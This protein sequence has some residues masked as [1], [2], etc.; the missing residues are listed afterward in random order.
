MKSV[1][2][3]SLFAWVVLELL[4]AGGSR[5]H[6]GLLSVV[7]TA[8]GNATDSN[9]DGTYDVLGIPIGNSQ[10]GL[11]AR[12]DLLGG[13]N[14][15]QRALIEFSLAGLA[16]TDTVTSATFRF[17]F[18]SR[19]WEIANPQVPVQMVGYA[20][21]GAVTMADATIAGPVVVPVQ[22]YFTAPFG[23]TSVAVDPTFVQGLLGN[24][25]FLGVRIEIVPASNFSSFGINS[26]EANLAFFSPPHPTLDIEFT[27]VQSVPEPSSL[28]MTATFLGTLA[29]FARRRAVKPPSRHPAR[30]K[31]YVETRTAGNRELTSSP[32]PSDAN[33]TH[34]SSAAFR[35]TGQRKPEF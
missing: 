8:N 1:L 14:L 35:S 23:E 28:A 30:S 6:A 34:D 16:P 33:Q 3:S 19:G 20:G 32:R 13:D 27:S 25:G 12:F 2:I 10:P 5:A 17:Y 21:D 4:G 18:G 31:G 22:D 7:A 15:E 26:L 29:L 9:R 11:S 24:A